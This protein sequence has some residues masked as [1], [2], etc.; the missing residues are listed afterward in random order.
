MLASII[1][2]IV[3]CDSLIEDVIHTVKAKGIKEVAKIF[4]YDTEISIALK[5]VVNK[6][7]KFLPNINTPIVA[8]EEINKA[9]G[10]VDNYKAINDSDDYY[11]N[12]FKESFAETV[13]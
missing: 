4:K 6:L 5:S 7:D 12:R 1:G 10:V 13:P 8:R 3:W 9:M 2:V 11:N